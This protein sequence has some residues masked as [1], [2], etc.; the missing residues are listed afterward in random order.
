MEW[1]W[2][3]TIWSSLLTLTVTAVGLA[4]HV[5]VVVAAI[6]IVI[7]VMMFA[8][9]PIGDFVEEHP[10]VKMLT[11]SFGV[12]MFNLRLHQIYADEQREAD[13]AARKAAVRE[14]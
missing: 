8:A 6:V 9:K 4:E 5:E 14:S 3:I 2:D 12:E 1:L 7:G 13:E 10:T 11:F